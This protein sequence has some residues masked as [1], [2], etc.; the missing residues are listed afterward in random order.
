MSKVTL[1]NLVNLQNETTA[2]NAINDNNATLTTAIDNTLSRDGSSPSQMLATLDMNSNRIINLPS[3][4][5]TTEPV[6]LAQ[7]TAALVVN[8]NINTGLTG[9]PVSAAMQ[10][11]VNAADLPTANFLLGNG[12]STT[13]SI[14]PQK[15]DIL[16][17]TAGHDCT[18]AIT[19]AIAAC[20]SGGKVYF[21]ATTGSYVVSNGFNITKPINIVGDGVGTSFTGT[22][23]NTSDLFKVTVPGNGGIRGLCF[24][25]FQINVVG[26]ANWFHLNTQASPFCFLA[27]VE[28]SRIYALNVAPVSSCIFSNSSS[29]NA[30]FDMGFFQNQFNVN[31]GTAG[32]CIAMVNAGDSIRIRDSILTGNGFGITVGQVP[33]AGN[34]IIEGC[35][36][37]ASGGIAFTA[38]YKPIIRDCE[39]EFTTPMITGTAI[40]LSGVQYGTI[41]PNQIQILSTAT[42][43]IEALFIGGSSLGLGVNGNAFVSQVSGIAI[44]NTS[45]VTGTVLGLEN[46]F[47]GFG[48]N[49]FDLG[50]GTITA[51]HT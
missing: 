41:G 51:A 17:G 13:L 9:V 23:P 2:V 22:I 46:T 42:G 18:A 32:G 25:N 3:A 31:C 10:P 50:T 36:I 43:F 11:V 45:T 5:S 30:Q 39:M 47:S 15:F 4:V 26:A 14:T 37:T 29:T 21:P 12:N 19:S 38:G 44:T 7:M 27:E 1:T 28:I 35:N 49:I 24:S 16:A 6:N 40:S 34:V 20:P 8:G 48:T 33:G